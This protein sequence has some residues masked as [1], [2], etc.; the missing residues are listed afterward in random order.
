MKG[1]TKMKAKHIILILTI[2]FLVGVTGCSGIGDNLNSNSQV[3]IDKDIQAALLEE[4]E[5][6]IIAHE[7]NEA[8]KMAFG[9]IKNNYPDQTISML[10]VDLEGDGIDEVIL[11]FSGAGDQYIFHKLASDVYVYEVPY[12]GMTNIT[13]DKIFT[14]SS[15]ADDSQWLRVNSFTVNGINY[16][17]IS[18]EEREQYQG[19][20]LQFEDF[21]EKLIK[22][23]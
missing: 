19:T 13:T 2:G 11:Q 23:E 16:E 12:R 1:R 18:S 15:G 7:E 3:E 20:V 10:Q 22:G 4:E 21:S 8:V 6:Y 17:V 5:F 14:A 9:D